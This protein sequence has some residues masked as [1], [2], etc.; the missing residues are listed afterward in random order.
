MKTTANC[1]RRTAVLAFVIGGAAS[2]ERHCGHCGPPGSFRCNEAAAVAALRTY[3]SAQNQ[4]HRTDHYG[5]GQLVYANPTD[6]VGFPDLYKIGGPGSGGKELKLIDFSSAKA[7]PGGSPRA[8][9]LFC[10]VVF[11]DPSFDCG[12]CAYPAVYG[13]SGRNTFMIDVTGVIYQKDTGGKPVAKWPDLEA[14][15]WVPA[16]NG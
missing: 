9:Y 16:G 12:L 8:G 2:C 6:G 7:T 14:D 5:T 10:D 15:G 13:R 4:F 1:L 3:L 11:E